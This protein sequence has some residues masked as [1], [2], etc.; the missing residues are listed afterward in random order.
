M[1]LDRADWHS[2]GDFPPDLPPECGGTH[3]GMFLAWVILHGLQGAMHDEESPEELAA[4]R[5]RRMTGRDFLFRAC[6][7]KFWEE[8]LSDEGAAFAKGYYTGPDGTGYGPYIAEYEQIL[9]AG[10]PS[11]YHVDDTWENYDRIAAAIDARFARWKE[12][13]RAT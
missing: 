5:E 3:I 12:E 6:D 4:V 9:G 11:V 2:G 8:D 1:S 13:R 10:V 7:G